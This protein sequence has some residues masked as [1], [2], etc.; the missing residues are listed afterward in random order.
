VTPSLV[1]GRTICETRRKEERGNPARDPC[2]EKL[3]GGKKENTGRLT[4]EKQYFCREAIYGWRRGGYLA[5]SKMGMGGHVL[6]DRVYKPAGGE[7]S[8]ASSVRL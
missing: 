8:T 7:V 5:V 1:L 3:K 6:Q 4:K 2:L